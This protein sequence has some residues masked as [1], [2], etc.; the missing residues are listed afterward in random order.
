MTGEIVMQRSVLQG[1]LK[2]HNGDEI[3]IKLS[4]WTRQGN[5]GEF[6]S[7]SWNSYKKKEEA[8]AQNSQQQI[9]TPLS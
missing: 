6:L 9:P 3:V 8:P 4:A 1:L 2:E 7:V 5:Y